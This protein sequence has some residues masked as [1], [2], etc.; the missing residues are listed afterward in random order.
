MQGCKIAMLYILCIL[1]LL[2]SSLYSYQKPQYHLSPT[3]VAEI[4]NFSLA[5]NSV[6]FLIPSASA[7]SQIS[8][9]GLGPSDRKSVKKSMAALSFVI[10]G[11]PL[12]NSYTDS[13]IGPS[14]INPL[15]LSNRKAID[16]PS[17]ARLLLSC[18]I[19]LQV[20]SSF[21]LPTI[22]TLLAVA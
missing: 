7:A 6:R 16:C 2:Q 14:H 22:S 5:V 15:S 17:G 9:L 4:S 1:A 12:S 11:S 20:G 21:T 8:V 18:A 3:L 13:S 10:L 19:T